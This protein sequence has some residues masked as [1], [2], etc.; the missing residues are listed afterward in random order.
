MEIDPEIV[1][2]GL[3][4]SLV[5]LALVIATFVLVRSFLKHFKRVQGRD[6]ERD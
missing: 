4:G 1:T 3:A 6:E 2:P 5:V